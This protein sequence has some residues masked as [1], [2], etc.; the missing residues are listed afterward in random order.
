MLFG[1]HDVD[2][3]VDGAH[4][5][6]PQLLHVVEATDALVPLRVIAMHTIVHNSV[7]IQI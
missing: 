3:F 1:L 5:G 6:R 4:D 2:H 7:Q